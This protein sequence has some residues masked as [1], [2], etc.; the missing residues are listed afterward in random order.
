MQYSLPSSHQLRLDE[1]SVDCSKLVQGTFEADQTI[2]QESP[3]PSSSPKTT[4]SFRLSDTPPSLTVFGLI[5]LL[6][7]G[8]FTIISLI[9]LQIQRSRTRSAQHL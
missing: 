9:K 5:L 3:I 8:S 4:V 6:V 7:G 2:C 1:G